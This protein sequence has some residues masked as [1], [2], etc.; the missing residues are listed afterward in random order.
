MAR[1][2]GGEKAGLYSNNW[3]QA[4][5]AR[6]GR[7]GAGEWLG[8]A[9]LADGRLAPPLAWAAGWSQCKRKWLASERGRRQRRRDSPSRRGS[10]SGSS[11]SRHHLSGRR[12]GDKSGHLRSTCCNSLVARMTIRR[13]PVGCDRRAHN[14]IESNSLARQ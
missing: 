5:F 4:E 3:L 2:E 7:L 6:P 11:R 10:G 8:W 14:E 1:R 12:R 9:S 13:A